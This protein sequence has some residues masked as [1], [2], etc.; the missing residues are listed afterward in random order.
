MPLLYP[1]LIDAVPPDWSHQTHLWPKKDVFDLIGPLMPFDAPGWPPLTHKTVANHH[2][3]CAL[4]CSI[5]H[6]PN[7]FTIL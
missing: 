3:G 1:T 6:I 5:T 7:Y 4:A 2:H